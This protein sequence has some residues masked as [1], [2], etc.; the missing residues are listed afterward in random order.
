MRDGFGFLYNIRV[1]QSYVGLS[2]VDFACPLPSDL[3]LAF[4][5]ELLK[6]CSSTA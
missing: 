3:R 5:K 4:D 1:R 2:S 6:P